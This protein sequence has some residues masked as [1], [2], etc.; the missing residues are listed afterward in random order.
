M[1]RVFTWEEILENRIPRN[2]CFRHAR[3]DLEAALGAEPCVVGALAYGSV[4]HGHDT[5]RSDLDCLIIFDQAQTRRYRELTRSLAET[6]RQKHLVSLHFMAF[7]T[8]L[9]E[10]GHHCVSEPFRKHLAYSEKHGGLIKGAPLAK[11]KK[12][13]SVQADL[14]NFLCTRLCEL[15]NGW[16]QSRSLTDEAQARYVE[17]LLST[18]VQL[19]RKVI[20]AD[21]G[22]AGDGCQAVRDA[23]EE[24]MPK[25]LSAQLERLMI[26]D[27]EYTDF[28]RE[29]IIAADKR[30]YCA[31]LHRLV[32]GS[33]R[34]V[35]FVRNNL[36][37]VAAAR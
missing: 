35:D 34:T 32:E 23:Y 28:V 20:D 22:L 3:Y 27:V 36:A 31:F 2:D 25:K 18:P 13:R 7:D 6:I 11:L 1:G 4:V 24:R 16:A 30:R 17:L 8:V 9:A 29:Q 37:H 21:G 10:T 14:V 19:A 12:S 26:A 15:E 5:F 33:L